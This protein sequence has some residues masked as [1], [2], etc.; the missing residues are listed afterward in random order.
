MSDGQSLAV[1][2]AD[3]HAAAG[4]LGAARGELG[5]GAA[6]SPA[7]GLGTGALEAA[8]DVLAARLDFLASAIGEA[9]GDTERKLGAGAELY[10]HTD[11]H[12]MPGAVA[13]G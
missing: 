6:V 13:G 11:A 10:V 7:G 1:S 12:S 3:L 2:S 5:C 4:V 8:L 9:V